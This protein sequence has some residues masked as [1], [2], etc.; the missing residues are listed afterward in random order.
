[1]ALNRFTSSSLRTALLASSALVVVAVAPSVA[2]AA[3]YALAQSTID[4]LIIQDT[5]HT[6]F[7]TFN[8]SSQASSSITVAGGATTS[9]STTSDT[10]TGG[11]PITFSYSNTQNDAGVDACFNGSSSHGATNSCVNTPGA[12]VNLG[13]THPAPQQNHTDLAAFGQG[14][15][16]YAFATSVIP[17]T[18]INAFG[19]GGVPSGTAGGFLKQIAETN[20]NGAAS[21]GQSGQSTQVWTFTANLSKGDRID[22]F[23]NETTH[24]KVDS[25]QANA[26]SS[27][28]QA[29]VIYQLLL[30]TDTTA[31]ACAVVQTVAPNPDNKTITG[32][33]ELT[34]TTSISSA[35]GKQCGP[36]NVLACDLTAAVT[37][38]YQLKFAVIDNVQAVAT[39][40]P[41]TLGLMGAGLLG[42][43][44]AVRR[45]RA[46]KAA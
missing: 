33:N 31:K 17:S 42:L 14:S 44:A 18:A 43:G 35:S 25:S 15:A 32:T 4:H 9:V 10:N 6:A 45:R 13:S 46:K 2:N 41:A 23:Y 29:S 40:E 11:A 28:A 30:C 26:I 37:G 3:A 12:L 16:S 36:N 20:V 19:P 24:L 5:A 34:D 39:P 21:T 22:F 7:A 27:I 38:F 8:F 1:M